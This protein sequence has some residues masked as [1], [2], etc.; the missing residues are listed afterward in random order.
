MAAVFEKQ[1]FVKLR[2][3]VG[4][5]RELV[6][7]ALVTGDAL[8]SPAVHRELV[9]VIGCAELGRRLEGHQVEFLVCGKVGV[10]PVEF[11]TLCH[12]V[13]FDGDLWF[14]E[15][16]RLAPVIPSEHHFHQRFE[17]QPDF[18][19]EL[20]IGP[21]RCRPAIPDLALV[22]TGLVQPEG[23]DSRERLDGREDQSDRH[24]PPSSGSSRTR[25]SA[26]SA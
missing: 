14:G 4:N 1:F 12:E 24:G 23:R 6:G 20:A 22:D 2:V 5:G 8:A 21:F 3:L 13:G 17:E 9:V 7:A 18:P 26:P 11:L 15:V 16:E 25:T 10:F 19:L